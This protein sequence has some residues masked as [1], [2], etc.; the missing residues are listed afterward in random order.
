MKGDATETSAPDAAAIG[1]SMK[2]AATAQRIIE[3]A[4]AVLAK[5]GVAGL[6]IGNICDEA[7]V[8]RAA[9]H[10]HFGD[11]D[12]LI[13][14]L[15]RDSYEDW[16]KQ[17]VAAAHELP[18]GEARIRFVLEH[19][20]DFIDSAADLL[21]Y[22]ILGTVLRN[23]ELHEQLCD[24]YRWWEETLVDLW[25]G[26]EITR[27]RER[28]LQYARI[29]RMFIDGASMDR[30]LFEDSSQ[31]KAAARALSE[32]LIQDLTSGGTRAQE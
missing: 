21:E 15:V 14:R 17:S 4:R 32:L 1:E 7:G 12:S 9:I 24:L 31:W 22:E 28:L 6:S 16:A 13:A 3:A 27:D 11:K 5:K 8:Y 25:Y 19:W 30:L 29:A 10:Y 26:D 23:S 2:G 20:I 18:E